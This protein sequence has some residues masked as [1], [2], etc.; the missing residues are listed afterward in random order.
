MQKCYMVT[1]E[2]EPYYHLNLYIKYDKV[3]YFKNKDLAKR[4]AKKIIKDIVEKTNNLKPYLS[5]F[6]KEIEIM[7]YCSGLIQINEIPVFE[8]LKEE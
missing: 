7:S 1:I 3:R 5:A 8:S 6:K 2:Y 4:Y